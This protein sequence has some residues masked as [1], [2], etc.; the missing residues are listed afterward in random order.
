MKQIGFLFDEEFENENDIFDETDED[1][2]KDRFLTFDIGNND[3]GI[4]IC[5]ITE[6]IGIQPITEIPGMPKYL[7]GVIN[8]RGTVVPVVDV[9]IRFEMPERKY[10]EKTCV[11]IVHINDTDI[12]LVVDDVSE[13]VDIPEHNILPPPAVNK[14]R[15]SRFIN[16]MGKI[17]ERVSI[18]LDINKLLYDKSNN[19]NNI[20]NTGVNNEN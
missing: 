5:Y 7:K 8:L 17:D 14:G 4:E 16:G 1:T 6:I 20:E 9:R 2:L 12:G 10:D 3:Y 18:L 19:N 11:I 13:V 15:A